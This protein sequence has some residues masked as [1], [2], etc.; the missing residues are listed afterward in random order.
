MISSHPR[1]KI[2]V[3]RLGA[4]DLETVLGEKIGLGAISVGQRVRVRTN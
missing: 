4:E 3:A 1:G 2:D